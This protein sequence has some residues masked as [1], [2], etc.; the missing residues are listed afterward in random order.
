MYL[1]FEIGKKL[2]TSWGENMKISAGA[3]SCDVENIDVFV[4]TE[5]MDISFSVSKVNS[6]DSFFEKLEF[7]LPFNKDFLLSLNEK[8]FDTVADIAFPER[9]D[10]QDMLIEENI[11]AFIKKGNK[12]KFK[13]YLKLKTKGRDKYSSMKLP[14]LKS[15]MLPN[16]I[17]KVEDKNFPKNKQAVA[18]RWIM[19]GLPV[20]MAIRKIEVEL[21]IAENV[22]KK[23]YVLG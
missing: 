18:Y 7:Y 16:H 23:T 21:E 9:L 2:K 5:T 19:R 4:V 17:K 8:T 1:D 6:P 15:K 12:N 14:E 10:E 3:E 22:A 20:D 11:K 13:D